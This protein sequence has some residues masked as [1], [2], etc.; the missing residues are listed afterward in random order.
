[1]QYLGTNT[2]NQGARSFSKPT[3]CRAPALPQEVQS[4]SG[5]QLLACHDKLQLDTSIY[6]T[7]GS[8]QDSCSCKSKQLHRPDC[9]NSV[10]ISYQR[11]ERSAREWKH[12]NGNI[13]VYWDSGNYKHLQERAYKPMELF[14][15]LDKMTQLIYMSSLPVWQNHKL[16]IWV[17]ITFRCKRDSW[18]LVSGWFRKA[19][20]IKCW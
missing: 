9:C 5:T 14:T 10:Q 17:I 6:N 15:H 12:P 3:A 4:G 11:I 7:G 18:L 2:K 20:L 1:M 13:L 19:L 16:L 8:V